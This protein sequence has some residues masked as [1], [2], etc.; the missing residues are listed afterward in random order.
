MRISLRVTLLKKKTQ[1]GK[2]GSTYE[3]STEQTAHGCRP[4]WS[5]KE[6]E[7]ARQQPQQE[8]S[9]AKKKEAWVNG[10]IN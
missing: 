7:D 8:T 6:K 10:V 2:H 5:E 1:G 4:P 3:R 9:C